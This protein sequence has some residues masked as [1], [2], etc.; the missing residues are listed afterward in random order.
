MISQ[1]LNSQKFSESYYSRY[2]QSINI[3]RMLSDQDKSIYI[4]WIRL[5]KRSALQFI[6]NCLTYVFFVELCQ[7]LTGPSATQITDLISVE[8]SGSFRQYSRELE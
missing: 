3:A 1:H 7:D 6:H 8:N 4:T 2:I 5:N